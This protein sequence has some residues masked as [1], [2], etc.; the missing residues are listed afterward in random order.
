MDLAIPEVLGPDGTYGGLLS[1]HW[2]I[3]DLQ[4]RAE[5]SWQ[6]KSVNKKKAIRI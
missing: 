6:V 2:D 4:S 1:L 5:I 3:P